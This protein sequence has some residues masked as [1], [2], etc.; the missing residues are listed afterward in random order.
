[1]SVHWVKTTVTIPSL[2]ALTW[3]GERTASTAAVSLATLAMVSHAPVSIYM[4]KFRELLKF[5]V[6][7]E[8]A[9]ADIDECQLELDVCVENSD[10]SDTQGSYECTCS[11]GYRGDG[12]VNCESE[13]LLMCNLTFNMN[14]I[15]LLLS[16][17]LYLILPS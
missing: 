6:I 16:H 15:L 4:C 2:T 8:N 7:T 14:S 11:S 13:S 9:P 5:V 3:W 10:C 1:M 17:K 12:L